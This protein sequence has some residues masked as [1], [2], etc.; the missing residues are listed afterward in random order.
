MFIKKR[1]KSDRGND[2]QQTR[3]KAQDASLSINTVTSVFKKYHIVCLIG[4]QKI[5]YISLSEEGRLKF[6]FN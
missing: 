2:L 6:R 1:P 4:T 5:K 3:S